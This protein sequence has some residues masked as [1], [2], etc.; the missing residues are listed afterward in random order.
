MYRTIG[1]KIIIYFPRLSLAGLIILSIFLLKPVLL[2]AWI[3]NQNGLRFSREIPLDTILLQKIAS[4]SKSASMFLALSAYRSGKYKESINW[5]E[6]QLD[7]E[8]TDPLIYWWLGKNRIAIGQLERGIIDFQ[9]ANSANYFVN[10]CVHLASTLRTDV[11]TDLPTAIHECQLALAVSR[12]DRY[13]AKWLAELFSIQGDTNQAA[14]FFYRAAIIERDTFSKFVLL[15]HSYQIKK[16]WEEAITTY[17]KAIS[18]RPEEP[19]PQFEVG[20]ILYNELNRISEAEYYFEQA[21]RLDSQNDL[22][23]YWLAKVSYDLGNFDN[24]LEHSA[25]AVELSPNDKKYLLL[26]AESAYMIKDY[27]TAIHAY[28]RIITIDPENLNA[29]TRLLDIEQIEGNNH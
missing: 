20:F 21:T 19:G 24:S 3:I 17:Q 26:W 27:K 23:N 9:M 14:D 18:L 11:P 15:G 22:S 2:D 12:S 6:P 29:E 8:E 1:E 5:L 4:H 10:N 16:D 28:Q 13:I 7:G 25:K